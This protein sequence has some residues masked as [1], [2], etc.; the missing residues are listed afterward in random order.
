MAGIS[1]KLYPP[2]INGTLPAFYGE[3]NGNG[4]VVA[5]ITVPFS[6]NRA[7]SSS[8]IGG[9]SLKIKTVQS[10]T[11]LAIVSSDGEDIS[12][13]LSN[14]KVSFTLQEGI[15]AKIKIGQFLK[16][17]LAYKSKD[18]GNTVGY[19]STV[20]IIKYTSK[21]IVYIEDFKD[22][23]SRI[24]T[25]RSSY[26]GIY[27][28]SKD[29]SERPYSYNFSLFDKD[30]QLIESSGWLLHNTTINNV[31]SESLSLNKTTDVYTFKT[32][33][34]SDKEYFLQY[35]VRTINNLEISSPLYSCADPYIEP[36]NFYVQ[37]NAENNFEEGYIN[38]YLTLDPPEGTTILTIAE[39]KK[40]YHT[41]AVSYDDISETYTI[42]FDAEDVED[43]SLRRLV[44][45]N[46]VSIE[47][48]RAEKTD[49]FTTWR[50]M[51]RVYI[52]N[53]EYAIN[54]WSFKDF[55]V[56]QG[57]TYKYCFRQYNASN[58][59]SERTL[60]NEVVAD[61]EDMFLWDGKKQ[62]KIRF[63]P[64]V[65]SF[66]INRLEQKTDTIGSKYPFIFR[67]GQVEYKEFP[68][69]GL[70][71]Y[72]ADNNEMFVNAQEDLNII[73]N[74]QVFRP[75][76]TP[77]PQ[78]QNDINS[79][80]KS[81]ENSA[82]VDSIGYNMRAE[83]RFKLKLLDWLGNG[84]I[85]LFRSPAEGNYLVRL[86][87]ISL[88]P[89]DRVSRML[90]TFSCTAYEVEEFTYN[91]LI[92]LGF[93]TP[94]NSTE[95]HLDIA[96][97]KLKDILNE[98]TD[99][100]QNIKIN[101]YP[102]FGYFKIDKSNNSNSLEKLFIRIGLTSNSKTE[103]SSGTFTVNLPKTDL[104]DL[105]FCVNDQEEL[106]DEEDNTNEKKINKLI[107]LIG[108]TEITYQYYNTNTLTGSLNNIKNAYLIN[109]IETSIGPWNKD[110]SS[111]Y[112]EDIIENSQ[113]VGIRERK[114]LK[115][116]T[117]NFKEKHIVNLYEHNNHYYYDNEYTSLADDN[118]FNDKLSVYKIK[119][120]GDSYELI[121]YD[122]SGS[123]HSEY[124]TDPEVF[125]SLI[126]NEGE[127]F[128]FTE[129]PPAIN[130]NLYSYN[131]IQIGNGVYLEYACQ[132]KIIEY[133]APTE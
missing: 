115:I 94:E 65:S 92:S 63:N 4:A 13:V 103:I 95:T 54:Y 89:E 28:T 76:G 105:Y 125:V 64:K 51:Q 113:I 102:I 118:V 3:K 27:E 86:L 43:I 60:S 117:L 78:N 42:H 73:L 16:V 74:P 14:R 108:D 26:T 29:K 98:I 2:T 50:A 87:N 121:Y 123:I 8:E 84:E 56:E 75:F 49:N 127:Q 129:I 107:S 114:T 22:N 62:V 19:Y 79:I 85:K 31:A 71:S 39:L 67:N 44:L 112:R 131:S 77:V 82:T 17:Q 11:L 52:S 47:I 24:E 99:F 6:M 91:N 104:P 116:Y 72:L 33:V 23:Q 81:W 20:G 18:E 32:Q 90:H 59:Q 110:F 133:N 97:L 10:N 101:E 35:S 119:K 41:D 55:T 124:D 126:T 53:Y 5:R 7:V 45:N 34:A 70:I 48:Y 61:F 100:S 128:V 106:F 15:L 12:N 109:I 38:T 132:D 88:T 68:I 111:T 1:E 80:D 37:L 9:F 83:R 69:S 66:K 130:L 58:I 57:V 21:P 46:P 93:L 96:T 30:F 120:D 122:H 25:F 36:E 40:L